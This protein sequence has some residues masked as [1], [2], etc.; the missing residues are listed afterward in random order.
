MRE[1]G[2]FEGVGAAVNGGETVHSEGGHN[3]NVMWGKGGFSG[4][5]PL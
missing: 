1:G 3:A 4:G 2:N 5:V